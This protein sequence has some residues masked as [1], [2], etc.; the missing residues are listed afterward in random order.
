MRPWL[1]AFTDKGMKLA[2]ELAQALDGKAFRCNESLSLSA[3]TEQAFSEADALIF[4]GAVGIAVRAVAPYVK[5]KASD[6]AVIV[7][8]ECGQFAVSLLS[9]HLGGANKLAKRIAAICGATPVITTATDVNGVFAVD[10]WAKRQN[11]AVL[12]PSRIKEISAKILGGKTVTLHSL[13][14]VQ[15]TP[16]QGMQLGQPGD[17]ELTLYGRDEG[18]LRVVPRIAVLGVGCKKQTS[19]SLLEQSFQLLLQESGLSEKAFYKVCTIDLKQNEPGLRAFCAN[20]GLAFQ[21][22]TASQLRSVSGTFSASDFVQSV[23]GVDNVCERSAVLGSEGVLYRKKQVSDG[24][25]MA[26]ALAPFAPDWRWN[27]E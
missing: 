7:V 23:T 15:G 8:D 21:T 5:S 18:V 2:N 24:V 22:F 25:T 10:E 12:D 17:F 27:D 6:P 26:V 3:W 20:R 16:P 14:P 13:W 11:C 19:Q 4:V 9:G 1:L